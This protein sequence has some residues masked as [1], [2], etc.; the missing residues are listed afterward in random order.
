MLVKPWSYM[1][2]PL[3]C[4][5]TNTD[6]VWINEIPVNLSS[7][8]E[9]GWSIFLVPKQVKKWKLKKKKTFIEL[10]IRWTVNYKQLIFLCINVSE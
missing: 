6:P 5:F 10:L 9:N 7:I 1:L 2:D 8:G 3:Y 4:V